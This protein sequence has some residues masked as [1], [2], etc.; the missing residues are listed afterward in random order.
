MNT[1]RDI[2]QRARALA[3][4]TPIHE[5]V[6]PGPEILRQAFSLTP[7]EVQVCLQLVRDGGLPAAARNRHRVDD[8]PHPS[9]VYFRQDQIHSQLNSP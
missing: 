9:A 7:A 8:R 4:V 5:I 2:F 6:E 1:A 3:V